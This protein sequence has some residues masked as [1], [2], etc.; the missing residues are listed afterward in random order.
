[1]SPQSAS[2]LTRTLG[3][4]Q[5]VAAPELASADFRSDSVSAPSSGLR[6]NAGGPEAVDGTHRS[7]TLG[8]L[9]TAKDGPASVTVNGIAY[10]VVGD[11]LQG[12]SPVGDPRGEFHSPEV[13]QTA[14]GVYTFTLTYTLARAHAC[15]TGRGSDAG[16]PVR[17]AVSATENSG[18]TT[19]T[20]HATMLI[21]DGV[22]TAVAA[23]V[24]EV[25]LTRNGNAA[26]G[27]PDEEQ[28]VSSRD[29]AGGAPASR[30][31]Y[32]N[33]SG[34][35]V[36]KEIP[37]AK[38]GNPNPS[39]TI[40]DLKG[41]GSLTIHKDGTYYFTAAQQPATVAP[42]ST[43]AGVQFGAASSANGYAFFTVAD[44]IV[45]DR[46]EGLAAGAWPPTI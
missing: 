21:V 10:R 17:L 46:D 34:Q 7:V 43:V 12:F 5:K 13:V 32:I 8:F 30:F 1:M 16:L 39:V 35:A 14:P 22:P 36:W 44:T 11:R 25:G 38:P 3:T 45:A 37:Q 20:A 33:Q 28:D 42:V 18:A 4:G 31:S 40:S 6:P 27:E 19:D 29:R 23:A 9:I 15:A 2:R 41:G 26:Y 24:D